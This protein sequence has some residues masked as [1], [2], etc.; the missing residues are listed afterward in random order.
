MTNAGYTLRRTGPVTGA[1]LAAEA[2]VRGKVGIGTYLNDLQRGPDR[3]V[4]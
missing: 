4:M 1:R 2:D 3:R